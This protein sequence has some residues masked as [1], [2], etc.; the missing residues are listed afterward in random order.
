MTFSLLIF[1][2]IQLEFEK[3]VETLNIFNNY[4]PITSLLDDVS[5]SIASPSS[6][7]QQQSQLPLSTGQQQERRKKWKTREEMVIV[8]FKRVKFDYK[9]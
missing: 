8:E 7:Q 2:C 5:K 1:D 4:V 3:G 6:D 9:Q